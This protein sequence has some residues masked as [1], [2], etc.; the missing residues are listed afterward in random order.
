MKPAELEMHPVYNQIALLLKTL[1]QHAQTMLDN[2]VQNFYVQ[3]FLNY[4]KRLAA[5]ILRSLNPEL[6]ERS[7]TTER[8][9]TP[10]FP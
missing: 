7:C 4:V 10:G 2:D 3:N 9:D 8:E 5:V 1:D 6:G